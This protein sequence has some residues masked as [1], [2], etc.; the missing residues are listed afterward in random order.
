[1]F[2]TGFIICCNIQ[3]DICNIS[4]QKSNPLIEKGSQICILRVEIFTVTISYVAIFNEKFPM[5]R[6]SNLSII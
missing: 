4:L 6:I 2:I 3:I 5:D 1:M